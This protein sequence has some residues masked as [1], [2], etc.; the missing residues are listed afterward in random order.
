MTI[1]IIWLAFFLYNLS[2]FTSQY[3]LTNQEAQKLQSN[4]VES[5]HK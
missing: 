5:S 1:L 3:V 4:Y 2:V